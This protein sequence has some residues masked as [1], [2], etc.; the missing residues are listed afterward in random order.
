MGVDPHLLY[1][2]NYPV[3]PEIFYQAI[4]LQWP[5]KR[6][7]VLSERIKP[8]QLR[9]ISAAAAQL[10]ITVQHYGKPGRR[11]EQHDVACQ[12]LAADIVFTLG[13]GVVETLLSGR[14]PFIFDYL[15]GDG[16]PDIDNYGRLMHRNYSGRLR[17]HAYTADEIVSEIRAFDTNTLPFLRDA[18]IQNHD[19]A[20]QVGQLIA[21]YEQVLD[22]HKNDWYYQL[23]DTL[24][25]D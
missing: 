9:A 23:H 16:I 24:P 8:D 11:I 2:W 5:P 17:R 25:V 6:A 13:R 21:H 20:R 22:P 4:P 14:V 12:M 15:G 18:A 10:G 3:D 7:L 19:A 1:Q